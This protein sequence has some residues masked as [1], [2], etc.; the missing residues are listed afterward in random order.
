MR[1]GHNFTY[2]LY[3]ILH[4]R[5]LYVTP[6]GLILYSIDKLLAEENTIKAR[7]KEYFEQLLER[8]KMRKRNK[9]TDIKMSNATSLPTRR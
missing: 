3:K 4:R 7:R 2:K 5:T 1:K 6:L 9:E 8:V